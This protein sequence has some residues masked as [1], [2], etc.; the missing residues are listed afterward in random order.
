MGTLT[1]SLPKTVVSLLPDV[2]SDGITAGWLN[3][4][5]GNTDAN[6]IAGLGE[7][8]DSPGVPPANGYIRYRLQRNTGDITLRIVFA[9]TDINFPFFS[10]DGAVPI[11]LTDLPSG[12]I[13]NATLISKLHSLTCQVDATNWGSSFSTSLINTISQSIAE[14]GKIPPVDGIPSYFAELFLDG[15]KITDDP[16]VYIGPLSFLGSLLTY[17]VIVQTDACGGGSFIDLGLELFNYSLEGSYALFQYDWIVSYPDGTPVHVGDRIQI[18]AITTAG[19]ASFS[20]VKKLSFKFPTTNGDGTS[21]ISTISINKPGEFGERTEYINIPPDESFDDNDNDYVVE[22]TSFILEWTDDQII[23]VVPP[24]FGPYEGP[25]DFIPTVSP[26]PGP[27]DP[28]EF[29]GSI[30]LEVL[31]ILYVDTSGVYQIV[32]GKTNDTLYSGD[33]DGTTVDVA[34]PKPFIRTGFVGS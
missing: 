32:P 8:E 15:L 26:S 25:V 3:P 6:L 31:E 29:S 14:D 13:M 23:I 33:R 17:E 10:L 21:V 2:R 4:I 22:D 27:L 12:F 24:G 7:P 28:T 34:I 9:Y 30:N 20:R 1:I 16:S 5:L 11:S 19:K 18:D